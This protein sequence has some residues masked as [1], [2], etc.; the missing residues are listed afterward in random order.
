MRLSY[1]REDLIIGFFILLAI[2]YPFIIAMLIF[3]EDVKERKH[4]IEEVRSF[5]RFLLGLEE[6]R[7]DRAEELSEFMSETFAQSI[8]GK[9][10]LLRTC[11]SYRKAYSTARAE[12]RKVEEEQ[13]LV[14]LIKKE[15]GMTQRLLSLTVKFKSENGNLKIEGVEYEKG[16]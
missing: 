10:G 11:Q 14:D 6:C 4:N 7:E 8:G 2:L 1:S 12:E 9:E 5:Y 13:V 3:L 16:D 15:K